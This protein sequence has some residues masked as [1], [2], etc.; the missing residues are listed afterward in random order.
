MDF[1]AVFKIDSVIKKEGFY[2][3]KSYIIPIVE[4]QFII[5]IAVRSQGG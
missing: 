4:K 2:V 1:N 3:K 5:S